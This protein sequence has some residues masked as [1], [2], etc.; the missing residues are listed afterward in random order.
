MAYLHDI[1]NEFDR[2]RTVTNAARTL[3]LDLL[4]YE[5]IIREGPES[6]ILPHP[7][8]TERAFVLLPVRDV[9]SD[10]IHPVSGHSLD[11]FLRHIGDTQNCA[12]IN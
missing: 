6:P 2:V 9:A 4:I 7:R 8:M 3:D 10:W 5:S 1:E 11:M 12:P